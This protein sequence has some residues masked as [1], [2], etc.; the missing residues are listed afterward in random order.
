MPFVTIRRLSFDVNPNDLPASGGA[1]PNVVFKMMRSELEQKVKEAIAV[2]P[3]LE[4]TPDKVMV[5]I[6]EEQDRN[7][8][9]WRNPTV[10]IIFADTELRTLAVKQA[11]LNVA[12]RVVWGNYP[13]GYL[14]SVRGCYST[15]DSATQYLK[16]T[17]DDFGPYHE[18][19]KMVGDLVKACNSWAL[20]ADGVDRKQP[21]LAGNPIEFELTEGDVVRVHHHEENKQDTCLAVYPNGDIFLTLSLPT[22]G[23]SHEL[24]LCKGQEADYY[25]DPYQFSTGFPEERFRW[26]LKAAIDAF[27]MV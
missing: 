26:W 27:A 6:P 9:W 5:S 8:D 2:I 10:E 11:A 19:R 20:L 22:E 24:S 14:E 25:H 3:E 16:I 18:I 12:C 1:P 15:I 21:M 17:T 23:D 13:E 4:I 7:G